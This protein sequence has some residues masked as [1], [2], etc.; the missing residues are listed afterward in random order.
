MRSYR[1]SPVA[2]KSALEAWGYSVCQFVF[3]LLLRTLFRLRYAD[4]RSLPDGPLI[5]AANHRS[6]IDPGVL[7]SI[8]DRP[9]IYM[10][11]AKYYDLKALNWFFRMSRCIVVDE[12]GDTRAALRASEEVLGQGQVLGIFPEGH[13]SRDGA[14]QPAQPGLGW[15]ARRTGAPVIPVYIGGTREVLPRGEWRMR[16]RPVRAVM[17]APM[18]YPEGGAGR[19]ADQAFADAVMVAIARLG[20]V[21]PPLLPSA[22]G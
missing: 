6:F 11:H 12:A 19:G 10:M 4:V 13:I 20:G 3:G 1:V 7:G 5:L 18:R 9:I 21:E 16:V 17:G 14:L 22:A 8:A 2:P 15:L